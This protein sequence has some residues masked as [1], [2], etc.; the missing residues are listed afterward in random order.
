[1]FRVSGKHHLQGLHQGGRHLLRRAVVVPVGPGHPVHQRLGVERQGVQVVG[2]LR[3]ERSHRLGERRIERDAVF[4]A[5]SDVAAPR[6]RGN[7]SQQ[8]NLVPIQK[9]VEV[10]PQILP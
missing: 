8:R 2:V 7:Q 3:G 5:L 4:A 9:H 10:V 1:M 6:G